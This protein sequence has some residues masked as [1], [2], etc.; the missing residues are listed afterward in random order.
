MTA[1]PEKLG[2]YSIVAELAS[3]GMGVVY[4]A[5][6]SGPGG[7]DKLVA[8]KCIH[9]HLLSEAGFVHRFLDEARL[10]SRLT[11]PHVASVFDVG[12]V[13]GRFY[14]AMEYVEGVP[15]ADLVE[16]A[17]SLP[18]SWPYFALQLIADAA[19]ALHVAHEL[20]GPDGQPLQVVHRDVSPHNLLVGFDG[21]VRVVDFGLAKARERLADST[22]GTMRGNYAYMAP[23]QI[24]PN[25]VIGRAV[26]I[27][28][29]GVVLHELLTGAPLFQ[30]K[31]AMATLDAVLQREVRS[32]RDVH[33][34]LPEEVDAIVARALAEDVSDRYPTARA[35]G[36]AIRA[37]LAR[38]GQLV[39]APELAEVLAATFP[40]RV[41]AAAALRTRAMASAR[42]GA[43]EKDDGPTSR[44]PLALGIAALGTG[45]IG[46]ATWA[47]WAFGG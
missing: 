26:D 39:G 15:L 30:R 10:A 28:A 12:E 33:P 17:P 7:F 11:H 27:W 6:V 9:P 18:A 47:V 34:S 2:R 36:A 46:L 5:R 19:E 21:G 31:H 1:I 8:L 24:V 14:L 13:D 20:T 38:S 32:V 41:Q 3:G 42:A 37:V 25:G 23:E 40:T 29:L 35:L 22:S 4:L 44:W 43:S 16:A 45:L